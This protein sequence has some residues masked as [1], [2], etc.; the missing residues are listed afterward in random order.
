M[1]LLPAEGQGLALARFL[2][3]SKGHFFVGTR[4]AWSRLGQ[5]TTTLDV[6]KPTPSEQK[7]AWAIALNGAAPAGP[8]LLASEFKLNLASIRRIAS[9]VLEEEAAAK[10]D[11]A[12]LT[13]RLWDACQMSVRPR[14]DALAQRLEPKAT[15]DDLVLPDEEMKILHQIADQVGQR[16]RVY[17][18]WGFAS[19][20][21]RGLGINALF[22]GDSGTGK[23]MAAEVIANHLRLNLYRIDLSAVVSKYI[24]ETEKNLRRLFDA[25]ED[26]G[27]ILFFDEADALFGKRSE[28]KDS[29][30][31]YANIEINYLLQRME[32][33]TRP[34]DPGDE[35]EE[36]ARHR[37]YAPP[38]FH[39]QFPIPRPHRTRAHVA[40]SFPSGDANRRSECRAAG[41]P[42][43]DRG[44]HHQRS[45]Q[46][47][48]P[49]LQSRYASDNATGF[50]VSASRVAQVG[51]T[52]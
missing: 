52:D 19:K 40:K 31:R 13:M 36:R 16:Y 34:G 23:T 2:A 51:A 33:Y 47:R 4:E 6:Q 37:L 29:H 28:V 11:D 1:A 27:A 30:D 21:N 15:W 43:L 42:H 44:K 3:R 50:G 10:D 8:G 18:E 49:R 26:G 48:F 32:A 25:A 39:R 24:G 20:M 14:L 46:F 22:A 41:A 12:S 7:A 38:A 9:E 17:E 5:A 35:Y 45:H